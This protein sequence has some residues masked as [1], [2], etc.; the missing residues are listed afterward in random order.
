MNFD[1]GVSAGDDERKSSSKERLSCRVVLLKDTL[2][3]MRE[4]KRLEN[5]SIEP[6]RSRRLADRSLPGTGA[7]GEGR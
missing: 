6:G 7:D 5:T 2:K 4:R 3:Q 1:C